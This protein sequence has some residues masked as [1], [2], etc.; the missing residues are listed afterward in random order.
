MFS[1]CGEWGTCSRSG[2]C[3]GAG[4]L[5]CVTTKS[6]GLDLLHFI[7]LPGI[8]LHP[9]VVSL[10]TANILLDVS[11]SLGQYTLTSMHCNKHVDIEGLTEI[12]NEDTE[13][14]NIF[15]GNTDLCIKQT[16]SH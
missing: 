3:Q 12:M 4:C 13:K 2:I 14:I 7:K 6:L 11:Y 16:N 15:Q 1:L 8:V 9:T 10:C 5:R